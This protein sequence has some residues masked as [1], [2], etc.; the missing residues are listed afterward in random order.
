MGQP[1]GRRPIVSYLMA[2]YVVSERHACVVIQQSRRV[3]QYQSVKPRR[4]DLRQ[5]MHE[6]AATRVRYG[7]RRIRVLLQREGWQVGQKLIFRLYREEGLALRKLPFHRRHRNKMRVQRTA[8][9]VPQAPNQA[10]TLDF[11]SDQLSNGQRFRVLTI[12]DVFTREAL[13]IK[14]G[15]HLKAPDVVE[16]LSHIIT[17]RGT[18]E[19]LFCDNGSEFSGQILDLWAYHHRVQIDFS[20]PGKPT[21]TRQARIHR[22]IQWSTEGRMFERALVR[23]DQGGRCHHSG[24][25]SRLQRESTSHGSQRHV[26]DR[27]CREIKARRDDHW[28]TSCKN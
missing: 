17:Q 16:E 10:W 7:Y 18:P 15:Q 19:R 6:I 27:I 12:V 26:T 22:N 23:V 21:D 28:S 1:A 5:R 13:A 20:R 24:L 3:Q 11:M 4:D 9:Q 14:I 8:R 25:A 2:H